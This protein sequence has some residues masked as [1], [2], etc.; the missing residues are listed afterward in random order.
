[1]SIREEISNILDNQDGYIAELESRISNHEKNV[2]H[3]EEYKSIFNVLARKILADTRLPMAPISDV[4]ARVDWLMAE[5][6]SLRTLRTSQDKSITSLEARAVKAEAKV[7]E[8]EQEIEAHCNDINAVG[9][10]L[11]GETM[12]SLRPHHM[13]ELAKELNK[14]DWKYRFWKVAEHIAP[15][16]TDWVQVLRNAEGVSGGFEVDNKLIAGLRKEKAEL[17]LKSKV[18]AEIL[19]DV[20][21]EYKCYIEAYQARLDEIRD[22]NVELDRIKRDVKNGNALNASAMSIA[23]NDTKERLE[24]SNRNIDYWKSMSA[25]NL[26]AYHKLTDILGSVR[27]KYNRLCETI[28]AIEVEV[29]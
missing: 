17:E 11:S 3:L 13:V 1:M 16:A 21:R 14:H 12:N 4:L 27:G 23:L 8:R 24:Q 18:D 15:S 20:K 7:K 26:D 22:L 25:R 28:K 10:A 29:T 2:S 9:S 19:S 6:E 5:L